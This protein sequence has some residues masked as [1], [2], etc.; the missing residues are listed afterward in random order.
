MFSVKKRKE[1]KK[2]CEQLITALEM[3]SVLGFA[4]AIYASLYID[5]DSIANWLYGSMLALGLTGTILAVMD[6]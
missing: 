1:L 6:K 4:L 3:I 2:L 5:W